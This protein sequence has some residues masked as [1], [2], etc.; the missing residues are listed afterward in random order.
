GWAHALQEDSRRGD[1]PVALEPRWSC[2]P[3]MG[4]DF[5]MGFFALVRV[6]ILD[7]FRCARRRRRLVFLLAG[8]TYSPLAACS[9]A[10]PATYDLTSATGGFAARAGRGQLAVLLPDATLPADSDRIVVRTNPQSVA[11]LAGAQWADKLP[12]LIQSRL[13]ESFQ[14]AHLM[15]A[16]GRPG[17]RA[18][19]SLQT[20]IRRFEFDPARG[21][22]KVEI[23][24]QI[25]GQSGRIIAGRLFS[26]TVPVASADSSAVASA[27]D[28][29]LRQIMREIVIWTAP[30]I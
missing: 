27:L 18:D 11:Y 29:A 6:L 19:F 14:N 22:A 26:G 2:A 10:P 4:M 16:V 9:S 5:V 12:S 21:E 25:L 17:M 20:G 28:A 15:R 13:I 7:L 1:A 30:K 24:A 23:S 8:W 3:L